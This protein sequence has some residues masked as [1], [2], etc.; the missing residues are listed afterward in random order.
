MD[1]AEAKQFDI[2]IVGHTD[3]VPIKRPA[4]LAK[5]PTNWHLSVHRAIGVMKVLSGSGIASDRMAVKG[6]GEF[7]PLE[8]NKPNKG[9]NPV[10][11]RVEIFILPS[12][13]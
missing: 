6:Y 9:G 13:K 2:V 7:Q 12:N 3:D 10:N 11:R 1:S 8:P 4:T 5:H